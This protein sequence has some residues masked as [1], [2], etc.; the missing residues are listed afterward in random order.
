MGDFIPMKRFNN[1]TISDL[2]LQESPILDEGF[3]EGLKAVESQIARGINRGLK[4]LSLLTPS[5]R[6]KA[7]ELATRIERRRGRLAAAPPTAEGGWGESSIEAITTPEEEL[8]PKQKK[9]G[10]P[11]VF[12]SKVHSPFHGS[13]YVFG[14]EGGAPI[15][16][17]L[18]KINEPTTNVRIT[19]GP[20]K[21]TPKTTP[22]MRGSGVA[23]FGE[24]SQKVVA[25]TKGG[26]FEFKGPETSTW[27]QVVVAPSSG[28]AYE[29]DIPAPAKPREARRIPASEFSDE[30]AATT[31]QE[32]IKAALGVTPVAT[33]SRTK[34]KAKGK[35]AETPSLFAIPVPPT[36]PPTETASATPGSGLGKAKRKVVTVEPKVGPKVGPKKEQFEHLNAVLNEGF[37]D[38]VKSN[39]DNLQTAVDVAAIGMSF[40]PGLNLVASGLQAA[41]AGVS[42][43]RGNKMAAA[44]RG[45]E[46]AVGL[47]PGLGGAA[48]LLTKGVGKGAKAAYKAIGPRT[49]KVA[50]LV[51]RGIPIEREVAR[52]GPVSSA[53]KTAAGKIAVGADKYGKMLTKYQYKLPGAGLLRTAAA[54]AAGGAFANAF[55]QDGGAGAQQ[56]MSSGGGRLEGAS[57]AIYAPSSRE[58]REFSFA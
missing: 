53:A 36:S 5:G 15:E 55:D 46:A 9:L 54:G 16:A 39:A 40:V 13:E 4:S 11:L 32:K 23:R 30:P 14:S 28:G 31:R 18:A 33:G 2:E 19:T 48:G 37:M 22:K 7:K 52:L 24:W 1:F 3:K 34:P 44:L 12:S 21:G 50:E 51:G 42:L 58:R 25:P 8:K 43:A 27:G 49:T 20:K 41:N 26:P 47:V 6:K 57:S 17:K 10:T 56:Q 29:L 45:A 35:P 38:W